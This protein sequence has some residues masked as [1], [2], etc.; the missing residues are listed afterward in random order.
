MNED[1]AGVITIFKSLV[2]LNDWTGQI[3]E[4]IRA[5]INDKDGKMSLYRRRLAHRCYKKQEN[6][7]LEREQF[8]KDCIDW[9]KQTD[10]GCGGDGYISTRGM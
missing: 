3:R 6:I 10:W 4:H 5:I 2:S 7:F 9:R 8:V 1:L